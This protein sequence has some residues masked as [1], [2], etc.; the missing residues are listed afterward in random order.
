MAQHFAA[1]STA[2]D[3][4]TAFGIDARSHLR[5]LGLG[6]RALLGLVGDRPAA[7]DRHRRRRI[8]TASSTAPTPWTSISAPRRS[9]RTCRSSWASSA[10]GIAISAA[11]RRAPSFPT[12]SVCR[13]FPPICSSSTWNRTASASTRDGK[14]AA[15]ETGPVV[16]GEPGT[17]GQHAFFQLLHQGTEYRA[18][19]NS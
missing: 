7:D 16:W 19:S 18:R 2:L 4:V 11:M 9:S 13:G 8:S 5:L 1:I 3:K 10:S 6:R 17:N 12:T 15:T 14:P